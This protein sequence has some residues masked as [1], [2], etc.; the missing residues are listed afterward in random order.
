[1]MI[2]ARVGQN[3]I[4]KKVTYFVITTVDMVDG[5]TFKINQFGWVLDVDDKPV[6]DPVA[7]EVKSAYLAWERS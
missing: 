3:A 1:M 2:V 6:P 4:L 7:V 5:R